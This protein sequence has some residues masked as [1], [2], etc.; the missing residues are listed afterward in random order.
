M[1]VDNWY[2]IFA[3][4]KLLLWREDHQG[5]PPKI[6]SPCLLDQAKFCI[7]FIRY[8]AH[9]SEETFLLWFDSK[10]TKYQTIWSQIRFMFCLIGYTFSGQP[11]CIFL[12]SNLP[13]FH[14]SRMLNM[15]KCV[16]LSTQL[17]SLIFLI[18]FSFP[19]PMN[20]NWCVQ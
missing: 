4:D 1:L 17:Q 18:C 6:S 8:K 5:P 11:S 2:I 12:V 3:I 19:S 7:L 13:K 10:A 16:C 20:I 9:K 14:R 15:D